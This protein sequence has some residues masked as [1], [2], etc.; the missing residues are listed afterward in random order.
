MLELPDYRRYQSYLKMKN[1]GY[2]WVRRKASLAPRIFVRTLIDDF[3]K[4][5]DEVLAEAS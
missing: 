3:L 1:V 5:K 4:E 2:L